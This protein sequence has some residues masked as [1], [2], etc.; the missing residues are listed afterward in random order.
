MSHSFHEEL[1][2]LIDEFVDVIYDT[3]EHFPKSELFG[4]VSQIRRAALS[5]ALNYVEGYGRGS[6]ASN[7][8][9]LEI[10]FSSLKETEYLVRFAKRRGWLGEHD[11]DPLLSKMHRIGGMLWGTIQ[12]KKRDVP[13][14]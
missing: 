10:S 8:H 5:V 12:I 13:A 14:S 2:S 1:R 9:F 3:S 6:R 4:S 7:R 11:A